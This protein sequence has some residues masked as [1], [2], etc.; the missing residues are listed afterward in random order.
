MDLKLQIQLEINRIAKRLYH[1]QHT[2]GSW[3]Y[4]FEGPPMTDAYMIILLR[5]LGLAEDE[6]QL[7]T[8][9]ATRI[10]SLQQANG[11]WKLYHDEEEG[12]LSST[13]EAYLGLLLSGHSKQTDPHMQAATSF[14][15]SQG[16]IEKAHL[17]TKVMLAVIGQYPWTQI[18]SPVEIILLPSWS[19]IT[20]FDFNC[21]GR[22]HFAPIMILADRK[23]TFPP[24][25]MPDLSDLY[26]EPPSPST[27]TRGGPITNTIKR[28]L[29]PLTAFPRQIRQHAL[30]KMERFLLD[31]IEPDGT[32]YSYASATILMI[33]A[34]LARGYPHDHPLITRAI[35]G[36]KTF[37]CQTDEGGLHLQDC[38]ATVWNTALLSHALQEAGVSHDSNVIQRSLEYL[39]SRQHNRFGDWQVHNPDAQPGGWGFSDI[40]TLN[41][42]I[43]D[44]SIALKALRRTWQTEPALRKAWDRG[45][46]W[47][48]S[49]QNDDGGWPS[50]EKNV[51]KKIITR[52]PMPYAEQFIDPSVA[53]LT[54]RTLAFLGTDVGMTLHNPRIKRAIDWLLSHQ[55]A[56]GSWFGRWG[57]SYLYGTWA[58]V[59]GLL[60]VGLEPTHPAIQKAITWLESTQNPDGGWGE[61]CKSDIVKTYTPLE[62][63]T[64]SQTAW[65]LDALIAA[66][67]KQPSPAIQ[68]AAALLIKL[69]NTDDWRSTYPTGTAVPGV[70]YIRYHSYN[71]IY[72]LL[73]LAHYRKKWK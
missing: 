40:N 72:P 2:D 30:N 31:R 9:L 35:Q 49:M 58:A 48:L 41:P 34:L 73:A 53:D 62:H 67:G 71:L 8:A 45:L 25:D 38:T 10:A 66:S 16:G 50:F 26:L 22:V 63:S 51:D 19:P 57:V 43:D 52:I 69:N 44:T 33:F 59:T 32:L 15:R 61:S 29:R 23:A 68:N 56:D 65:A 28:M 42:D 5:V 36:M 4:C 11:A 46:A 1:E 55:E 7:L 18:P 27:R 3:R 14:I 60:A 54:G 6:N 64:P 24:D 39:L 20:F 17:G 70:G 13:I 21:W 37:I 47:L 12:H